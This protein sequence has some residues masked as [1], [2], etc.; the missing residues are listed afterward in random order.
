MVSI[1]LIVLGAVA[2]AANPG[3]P[4]L[5]P[6]SERWQ[7]VGKGLEAA[8]VLKLP[9]M[10]RVRTASVEYSPGRSMDIYYPADFDFTRPVPA[11]V[12]VMGYSTAFTT[13]WFGAKLKDLGQYVSWGQLVAASGMIGVAY[14]TDYPDD[15]IDAVLSFLRSSGSTVGVDSSRLALFACSG[16]TLTALGA[17]AAKTADYRDSIRCGVIFYPVISY[18]MNKGE[19]VMP[20]PFKR[21]LRSDLPIFM[22]T[23]G[24]DRPEWKEAASAFLAGVKGKGYPLEVADYEQGVHGFDTDQ[25]TDASR[26]HISHALAFLRDKLY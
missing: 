4:T 21:E 14:E 3:H 7:K 20:A 17:L 24:N 10:D 12:F 1:A 26:A 25:D 13:Q 23:V 9:G 15:D 22:V 11:V 5:R 6:V 16:N 18:F 2:C 19:E 8:V